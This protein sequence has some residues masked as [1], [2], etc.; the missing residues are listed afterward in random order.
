MLLSLAATDGLSGWL[1]ELASCQERRLW[2]EVKGVAGF[3]DLH[4]W[5]A[6]FGSFLWPY[7]EMNMP[8]GGETPHQ[9]NIAQ[10]YKTNKP[11]RLPRRRLLAMT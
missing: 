7:K 3:C 4:I 6:F 8:R 1:F 11:W 10:R 2:R 9:Y 5:A